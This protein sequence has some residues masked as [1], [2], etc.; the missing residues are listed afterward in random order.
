MNKKLLALISL[1]LPFAAAAEVLTPEQALER[2]M[3]QGPELQA[4]SASNSSLRLIA[5]RMA[6]RQPAYYVFASQAPGFMVVSADDVA[7]PVLGYTDNGAYDETAMPPSMKAWLDDYAVQIAWARENPAPAG[8]RFISRPEYPTI[9]PMLKTIWNQDAPFNDQC[10]K[11][12]TKTCYTGCVATAM[13]QVINYHKCPAA[14]GTGS[15]SYTWNG[16]TLSFDYAKNSF[17][18]KNML[19]SYE[20]SYTQAQADAVAKLMYA[21]GVSVEMK[22]GTGSSEAATSKVATALRENFGYRT[23]THVEYRKYYD[24]LG[25]EKLVYEQLRDF[26]PVQYSGQS[27][28]GGHSFV[29]DG[30]N[31]GG[32]F[33]INWG[34]SGMSDGYFLLSTP[35]AKA[36]EAQL[37]ATTSVSMSSPTLLPTTAKTMF[38]TQY[39]A[40]A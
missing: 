5:T 18:W 9:A 16:Q 7:A 20:D 15:K 14:N 40:A 36:S 1:A 23:D 33:H 28:D 13:A 39:N 30:Y 12:G 34:W 26:G 19:N 10:P 31:A 6:D 32:F 8:A 17:D 38:T 29:C 2:A 22:Y 24:V 3:G 21:C 4:Q 25:W 35:A 37:R 11:V 27:N